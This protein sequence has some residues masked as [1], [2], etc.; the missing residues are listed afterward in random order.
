[1]WPAIS[2]LG[3][4]AVVAFFALLGE[5][6]RWQHRQSERWLDLRRKLAVCFLEAIDEVFKWTNNVANMTTAAEQGIGFEFD[7]VSNLPEAFQR[8]H[9]ADLAVQ[10]LNTELDIVG[11]EGERGASARLRSAV[12]QVTA[13]REGDDEE[14]QAHRQAASE[15]YFAARKHFE[16]TVRQGL[17]PKRRGGP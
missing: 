3:A 15:G 11:S 4:A 9:E 2:A 5:H 6:V 13:H 1:V 17:V 8:L 12:W 10:R 14:K 16:E 7:G